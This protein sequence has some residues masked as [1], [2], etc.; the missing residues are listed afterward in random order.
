MKKLKKY[1]LTGFIVVVP[2]FVTIYVLV[3]IFRFSDNILGRYINVYLKN[4]LGFYIPGIGFLIGLI[5]IIFAGYLANHFVFKRMLIP[6]EKW[7]GHLP[8]IDKIYPGLKQIM[9][10]F[11]NQKDCGFKNVVLIEYPSKGLWSLGFVTNEEVSGI[12][13]IFDKDTIAVLVPTTPS[14][15]TGFLVFVPRSQAKFLDIPISEAIKIIISG[16]VI[17]PEI[18][19]NINSEKK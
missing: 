11:S 9:S 8:L 15:L 7:F 12:S 17:K 18:H 5:I 13:D 14:P 1:L 19:C 10:F 16:G 4:F 2:I 6:I 3:A